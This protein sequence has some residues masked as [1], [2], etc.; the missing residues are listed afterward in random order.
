MERTSSAR[1]CVPL[2]YSQKS[3]PDTIKVWTF[4]TITDT[5]EDN[6]I[7][8]NSVAV[9]PSSTLTTDFLLKLLLVHPLLT[10]P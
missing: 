5:I 6:F 3:L 10:P 8:F 7:P 9:L 4:S 1:T 2:S